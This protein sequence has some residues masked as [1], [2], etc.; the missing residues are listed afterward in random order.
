MQAPPSSSAPSREP[1][2]RR[3][4]S[5][6]QTRC[7]RDCRQVGSGR[8]DYRRPSNAGRATSL[9]HRRQRQARHIFAIYDLSEQIGVSPWSWWADVR[10]PRQ[11]ALFVDP[12]RHIQPVPPS[13]IAASFSMMKRLRSRAGSMRSSALQL[14]VLRARLRAAAAP[15]G[16]LPVA[17]MW[18]SAFAADDPLNAKL[19]DE[20]GIV[21]GTSHEEL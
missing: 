19:A 21:M 18:N 7:Q 11:D 12:G 2:D 4:D 9:G 14:K 5:S 10:I 8:N 15:E 3:L 1:A 6:P 17:A 16:Q 13:S 20:Y